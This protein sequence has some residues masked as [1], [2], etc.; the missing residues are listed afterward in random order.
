MPKH[1][2]MD[3]VRTKLAAEVGKAGGVRSWARQEG[4]SAAY[5]S[6][7]LNGRRDPGPLIATALRLTL[8]DEPRE[9]RVTYS[10][11]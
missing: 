7:V 11:A 1:L 8:H 2:T 10:P 5:V 3:Q 4:C 9:R 6:D